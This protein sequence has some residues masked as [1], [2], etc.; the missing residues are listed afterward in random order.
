MGSLQIIWISNQSMLSQRQLMSSKEVYFSSLTTPV[1]FWRLIASYGS[2]KTRALRRLKVTWLTT[3]ARSWNP[4]E[5]RLL[6]EERKRRKRNE[7]KQ[8]DEFTLH[9]RETPERILT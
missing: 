7:Q 5:K 2:L 1:L 6:K 4:L 8:D 9:A 3:N